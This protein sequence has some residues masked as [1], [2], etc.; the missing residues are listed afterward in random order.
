MRNI[1][2]LIFFIMIVLGLVL[3]LIYGWIIN[4]V[5]YENTSPVMLHADYK[6]DYVLMVAQIYQQDDNLAEAT[7]RLSL[8]N[9]LPAEQ[10]AADGLQTARYLGYISD[11][12]EAMEKLALA[13]LKPI[14]SATA[15]GQP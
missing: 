6:A 15:G 5:Q 9:P 3:G 12:L 7:R 8:L 4:P 1:R 11:D 13:L 10:I 2:I 14:P